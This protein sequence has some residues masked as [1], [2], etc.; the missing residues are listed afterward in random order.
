M[1]NTIISLLIIFYFALACQAKNQPISQVNEKNKLL[2]E[3]LVNVNVYK[4]CNKAVVNISTMATAE[5]LFFNVSP[6]EGMGS[7]TIIS[8]DGYILTNNHV[9]ERAQNVSVTLFDGLN[10]PATVVGCDPSNDIA[11]IKF[12]PPK[13]LKL[14]TIPFGDS[15]NLEVG[16]KVLA[17]GNP[18]GLTRTLTTGIVSSLG[19]TLKTE[20]GRLIKG[21]IQTDAAINPGNSGGPLLDSQGKMVGITTAILSRSGQSSGIGFAI[22]INIAKG[23]IPELIANHGIIRPDLGIIAFQP[24]ELGLK[25]IK[26][27]P[28]GPA[29]QAGLSG[30]KLV[31]YQQ[32]PFTIQSIDS[33]QADIIVGIDN[34]KIQSVDDLLSYLEKK[35]PGQ[36]VT[37]NILRNGN[38]KQVTVKL[39]VSST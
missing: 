15:N 18:F 19:R 32:G 26:L 37:I 12:N 34:H 8:N 31:V 38:P 13:N 7:G 17:I 24:T 27:D 23:I 11:I 10:L 33:T 28:N 2:P 20:T 3:E 5:D 6:K 9:I 30:P 35:K 25:I 22:P 4:S 36:N 21:V 39:G 14:T 16:R 29:A 1:K